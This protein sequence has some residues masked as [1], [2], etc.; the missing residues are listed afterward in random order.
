MGGGGKAPMGGSPPIP[1][2]SDGGNKIIFKSNPTV[3]LRLHWGF[4]Y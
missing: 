4:D 3:R 1:P 2:M